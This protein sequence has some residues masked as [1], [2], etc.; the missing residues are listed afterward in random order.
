MTTKSD[1]AIGDASLHHSVYVLNEV[2]AV[3]L[4]IRAF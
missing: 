2:V 4:T 1:G 3:L